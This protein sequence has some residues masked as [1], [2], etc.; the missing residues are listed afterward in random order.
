MD[1]VAKEELEMFQAIEGEQKPEERKK[2]KSEQ[3]YTTDYIESLPE[4]QRAELINGRV[5]D[6]A[7]PSLTHQRIIV[8]MMAAIRDYIK[9]KGG[10]CEVVPAPFGVFL[11]DDKRNFVEPDIS[12]ICDPSKLDDKGCHGA[13][14]WIIEVVS[15]SSVQMD[16]MI[17]SL[18]YSSAGVRE[19]WVIDPERG[20]LVAY[21]AIEDTDG[22]S[23]AEYTEYAFD[24]TVPVGIYPDLEIDFKEIMAGI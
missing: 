15:P 11:T 17:K 16:Y 14:D 20:T 18:K 3:R 12:V 2:Q 5:Y 4:G 1:A 10:P 13:P 21:R 19:Y 7:A 6:M 8:E 22:G 24:D 9:K 23:K